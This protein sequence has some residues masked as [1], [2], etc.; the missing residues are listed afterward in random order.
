MR[1]ACQKFIMRYKTIEAMDL[2]SYQREKKIVK[3]S[4]RE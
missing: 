2:S 3:E 1:I 4:R